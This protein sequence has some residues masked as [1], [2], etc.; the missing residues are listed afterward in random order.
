MGITFIVLCFFSVVR[1]G[2]FGVV[3]P[4]NST[5]I[6]TSNKSYASYS[7]SGTFETLAFA[8]RTRSSSSLIV[9]LK[10]ND[11]M[12]INVETDGNG[13]L[14]LRDKNGYINS[15]SKAS[16]KINDASVHYIQIN[17][18]AVT[19]NNTSNDV[20]LASLPVRSVFVGGLPETGGEVSALAQLRGC[21]RDVRMNGQ[22]L[23]FFNQSGDGLNTTLNVAEGCLREDVCANIS[24]IYTFTNFSVPNIHGKECRLPVL[25]FHVTSYFLCV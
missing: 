2:T 22:Q 5:F 3:N 13:Y 19:V 20:T 18:T 10:F 7:V 9:Q 24:G 6:P 4:F 17:R 1:W 16:L 23:L 12:F 14:R 11:S 8:V 25:E 21:I 15:S